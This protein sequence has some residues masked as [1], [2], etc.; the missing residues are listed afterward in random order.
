MKTVLPDKAPP[1]ETKKQRNDYALQA[2][3]ARYILRELLLQHPKDF[4][5]KGRRIIKRALMNARGQATDRGIIF[6]VDDSD[7]T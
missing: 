5:A 6:F 7:L 4:G 2:V 3:G 1:K